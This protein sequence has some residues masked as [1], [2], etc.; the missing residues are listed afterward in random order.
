MFFTH[1]R[2]GVEDVLPQG[3]DQLR[4]LL[5]Q[6]VEGGVG[7]EA[8]GRPLLAAPGLVVVDPNIRGQYFAEE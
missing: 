7:G 5:L 8:D 6:A 3:R 2:R 1:L 4:V